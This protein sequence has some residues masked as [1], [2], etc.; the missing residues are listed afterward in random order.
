MNWK[1]IIGILVIVLG[2]ALIIFV[3]QGNKKLEEGREEISSG[4]KK[5]KQTQQLFSFTPVTKQFGQGLTSGAQGKIAEGELTIEQYEKI[6]MWCKIGG[7]ALIVV[8]AGLILFCRT[9]RK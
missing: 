2:I 5:V 4:K 3:V 1:Q 8:G 7:I 9:K 6:F